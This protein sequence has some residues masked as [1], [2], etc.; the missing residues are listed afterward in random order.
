MLAKYITQLMPCIILKKSSVF[1]SI[2]IFAHIVK[3]FLHAMLTAQFCK[4]TFATR[5]HTIKVFLN[6]I[7]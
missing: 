3:L 2:L 5:T 6:A 4:K 1:S 7:N